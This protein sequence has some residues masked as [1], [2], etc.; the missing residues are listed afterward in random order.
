MLARL[1]EDAFIASQRF[2]AADV[3][4][5]E[6]LLDPLDLLAGLLEVLLEGAFSSSGV[7]F[8]AILGSAFRICFS[9]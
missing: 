8:F 2:A 3:Q 1:L 9:A 7:A 4:H 5:L 6:H